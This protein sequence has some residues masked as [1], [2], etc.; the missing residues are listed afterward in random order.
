MSDKAKTPMSELMD[1]AMKNYEQALQ[2]SLKLQEESSKWWTDFMTQATA[3]ADWQ[4][5]WRTTA[6]QS[7]PVVQKRMEESLRLLEQS[8]RTSLELLK[9]AMAVS[10]SDSTASAQTKLQELWEASLEALRNNA[11]VVSQ[12]NGKFVESW[13]QLLNGAVGPETTKA[14]AA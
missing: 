10:V 5:R 7:I 6:N 2:A 13:M 11:Q 14:K 8:S 12:A 3:P 9:Q 1:Q 4:N